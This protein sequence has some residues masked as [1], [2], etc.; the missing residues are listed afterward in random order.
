MVFTPFDHEGSK[1]LGMK[2]K[3]LKNHINIDEGSQGTKYLRTYFVVMKSAN[4]FSDHTGFLAVFLQTHRELCP[5]P[6]IMPITTLSISNFRL[7]VT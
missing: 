7:F 4:P 3:P 6:V 5:A 1:V 2:V